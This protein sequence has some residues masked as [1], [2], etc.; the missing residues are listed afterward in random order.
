V[1]N[2]ETS[3][4][5]P[6]LSSGSTVRWFWF[7]SFNTAGA[8]LVLKSALLTLVEDSSVFFLTDVTFDGLEMCDFEDL[9]FTM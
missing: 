2:L 8:D 4:D 1:G 3:M 6:I 7:S 9:G 5:T